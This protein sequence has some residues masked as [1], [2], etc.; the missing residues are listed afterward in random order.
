MTRLLPGHHLYRAAG[1]WRCSAPGDRFIRLSGPDEV[2]TRFQS[3]VHGVHGPDESW[4]DAET[5]EQYEQL[6]ALFAER[7]LL[8]TA[9]ARVHRQP[10]RRRPRTL[11]AG[12]NLLA[13]AVRELLAPWADVLSDPVDEG[14]IAATDLL[15]SCEG[16]LPDTRWDQY[17]RWCH[18]HDTP[19]H[20]AHFEDHALF[21][22]PFTVPGRT[23]GYRDLRGRRLA[24]SPMADELLLQWEYL[25]RDQDRLPPVPRPGLGAIAVAAGIVVDEL[26]RWWSTG[27]PD[28]VSYQ[29]EVGLSPIRVRAHPV[30]MLPMTTPADRADVS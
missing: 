3:L 26:E 4:S 19:W 1:T 6:C 20:R 14:T 12:Q 29:H 16:W 22:G 15:I 9:T 11:I 18:L 23:P 7:N 30:L 2:L 25:E 8:Q 10:V 21:L 27:E 28:P 13:G 24:A 17:D 5:Q